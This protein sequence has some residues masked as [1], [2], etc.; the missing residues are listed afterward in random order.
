MSLR[1]HRQDSHQM[2]ENREKIVTLSSF[3]PFFMKMF[4]AIQ[5]KFYIRKAETF[6]WIVQKKKKKLK[7]AKLCFCYSYNYVCLLLVPVSTSAPKGKAWADQGQAGPVCWGVLGQNT[8]PL[9][10]KWHMNVWKRNFIEQC[11]CGWL[12]V[13]RHI[14]ALGDCT[15]PY[16]NVQ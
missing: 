12:N 3:M 4:W 11:V 9:F 6:F 14:K 2:Y 13:T 10:A 1:R 7:D 8:E 15:H 5:V 16:E